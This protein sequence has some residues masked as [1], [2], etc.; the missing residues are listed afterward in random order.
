LHD[1][2]FDAFYVQVRQLAEHTLQWTF[3]Y[4]KY[5]PSGQFKKHVLL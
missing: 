1:K 5:V 3:V 4:V 2:H